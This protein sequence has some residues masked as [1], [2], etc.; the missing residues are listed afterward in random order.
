MLKYILKRLLLIIPTLFGIILLNFL[1]VQLSPGGPVQNTINK[2][3]GSLNS[4][5]EISEN[6]N[7]TMKPLSS[8][9]VNQDSINSKYQGLKGVD[10][11]LIRKVEKL[12]GFDKPFHVR[13]FQMLVRYL[14]FDFGES[15]YRNKKVTELVLEKMPVSISLGLWSTFLIYIICIP[16]G[17]RKAVKDGSKFDIWSSTIIIIAYAVPAFLFALLLIILFAGGNF[18]KIFPL[19][20]IVSDN[21]Q[22][23][24]LFSKII[25]YFWHM[26]LPIIS[27]TIGGFTSLTMLTKNSFLDEI[28]KQYVVTARSKG[29]TETAILY[30]HVFRNAM[31]IVI[32]GFPGAFIGMFFTGSLLIEV[33]FSLDGMGLLGYNAALTSDYPVLFGTLYFFSLLGLIVH[34]ISDVLYTVI[35]PRIDFETREV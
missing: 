32:S 7:N 17:I 14:T 2:I 26:A 21:W 22:Q 20:N 12:Y 25:D 8:N 15:Y 23:L 27:I 30:K 35:D 31:L 24:P 19:R 4:K 29:L 10:P 18:L 1:L 34:I 16:L 33:V 9:S 6:Y 13:F 11:D 5:T 3:R 28:H